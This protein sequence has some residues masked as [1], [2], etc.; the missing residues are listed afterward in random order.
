VEIPEGPVPRQTTC[1]HR[2]DVAPDVGGG[3]RR[4]RRRGED[5]VGQVEAAIDEPRVTAARLTHQLLREPAIRDLG[6]D[7]QRLF[8][9]VSAVVCTP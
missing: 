6:R 4:G 3:L 7:L 5:V 9:R 1:G 2:L 8:G